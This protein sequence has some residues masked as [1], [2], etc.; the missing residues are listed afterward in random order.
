[1]LIVF[2]R[3][4]VITITKD[5]LER[6]RN[7]ML[8]STKQHLPQVACLN[9]TIHRAMILITDQQASMSEQLVQQRFKT[10]PPNL[11]LRKPPSCTTRKKTLLSSMLIYPDKSNI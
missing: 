6:T 9:I 11:F 1:M 10:H 4:Q 5:A 2:R 7:K 8:M 3:D